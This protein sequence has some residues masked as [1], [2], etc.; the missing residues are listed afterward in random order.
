MRHRYIK[1]HRHKDI[2]IDKKTGNETHSNINTEIPLSM[3]CIDEGQYI[4]I[5]KKKTEV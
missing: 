3:Y 2:G 4:G 5:D 1:R